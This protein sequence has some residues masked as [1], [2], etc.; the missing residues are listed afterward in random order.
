MEVIKARDVSPLGAQLVLVMGP[1]GLGKSTFA[2]TVAEGVVPPEETLLIATLP[3]EAKSWKYQELNLD[4][5]LIE[6]HEG[7]DPVNKSYQVSG[8][9]ELCRVLDELAQ[10]DRYGAVILDN[11]TEAAEFAW[12]ESLAPFKIGDPMELGSGGN[13]F[14]PY[15]SVREK[16][17]NL[18]HRLNR[19]TGKHC[20]RPKHVIVPWHVQPPKEDD[21]SQGV[22]YVGKE[23]P[24]I[25]GGFRRRL[26]QKIDAVVFMYREA[27]VN[28][29]T[30]KTEL[31]YVLQVAPDMERHT[32]IPGELP[33]GVKYIEPRYSNLLDLIKDS[34]HR[35][36]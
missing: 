17:E 34:T 27:K 8:Y 7:W 4:T 36:G 11:G 3:R 32:K 12:H 22:E 14:A 20:V 23:L 35:G 1:P 31:N 25:R 13:R 18:I 6:E 16:M 9:S 30:M 28:K 19:L 26:G 29:K 33:E 10:D 2:A 24:M 5:I 15:G 21:D